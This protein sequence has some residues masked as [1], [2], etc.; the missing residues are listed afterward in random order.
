ME[1]HVGGAADGEPGNR[2]AGKVVHAQARSVPVEQG[3]NLVTKPG[4]VAELEHVGE[5]FMKAVEGNDA[6]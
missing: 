1:A 3:E 6:P 4:W 2:Q 5:I